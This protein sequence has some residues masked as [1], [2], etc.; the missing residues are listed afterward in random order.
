MAELVFFRSS[1]RLILENQTKL[2]RTMTMAPGACDAFWCYPGL[3]TKEL[4]LVDGAPMF[5]E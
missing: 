5:S 1:R 2:L 3:F 4:S